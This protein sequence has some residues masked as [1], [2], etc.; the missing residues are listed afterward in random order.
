MLIAHPQSAAHGLNLQKPTNQMCFF[1]LHPS[2]ENFLQFVGRLD[3]QGQKEDRV[4]VHLLLSKG[5]YDLRVWESLKE[6]Q[7]GEQALLNRLRYL[8][9]K[10]REATMKRVEAAARATAMADEDDLL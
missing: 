5:T 10:V 2:L 6:K 9:R 4:F 8:Q 3:R 1:D 7:D